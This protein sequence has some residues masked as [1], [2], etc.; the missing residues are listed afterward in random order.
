MLPIESIKKKNIHT[1]AW[2]WGEVPFTPS[3]FRMFLNGTPLTQNSQGR[4]IKM[5]KKELGFLD[6]VDMLSSNAW[7]KWAKKHGHG[8]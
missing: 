8:R 1:L 3:L 2:V 5:A 6:V 7:N 4:C